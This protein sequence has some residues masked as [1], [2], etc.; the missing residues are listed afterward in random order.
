MATKVDPITV[1]VIRNGFVAASDEMKINL[2]RT[3]YNPIIYEVLDFSVGMFDENG[4][5]I[6]Q[7]AGLPIFLGNLSPSVKQIITDIGKE[8]MS[9]GDIYLIND[10]YTVGTHLNDVVVCSP[11]FLE[12][13]KTLVGFAASRAHWLDIGAVSPGGWTTDTTE[14]Y[15]EGIRLRSIQLMKGGVM[16]RDVYQILRD[17]VRFSDSV[18]GDVRAQIAACHTGERRMQEIVNRYGLDTVRAAIQ[19]MFRME[20]AA[21]RAAIAAIPDGVYSAEAFMDDDGVGVKNPKVKVTVRIE[22]DEMTI[23]LTGS[24]E[25]CL[26]PINCG[27]AATL[28]GARIALKAVTSPLSPVN[29]GTFVPLKLVVPENCMFNAKHPAP[30]AVYGLVLIT[31]IDTIF[32][33]LAPA[34]P[35]KIPAAHYGDVS[36]IFIFGTDPRTKTPYLHVEAQG[37]GWGANK[38]RDGENVMIAIADGDT[39][40]VPVEIVEA[41]YPLRVERYEIRQDS[42]GPGRY[43]GGLGH[44]RDFR[45]LDHDAQFTTTQE[46]SECP[47]WGLF[48]GKAGA[49]NRVVINPGT[50]EEKIIQ[51]ATGHP[52]KAGDLL[53]NQTGGGGGYG[54]PLDRPAEEVRLDVVRGYVSIKAAEES[55]GVILDPITLAIDYE[56]TKLKRQQMRN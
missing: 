52:L 2:T 54:N 48:G 29:E 14:I 27:Y 11:I 8:N 12:D 3:A 34:I 19:E 15:Q 56:A 31:L 4:N 5:M 20:E 47:P 35:H 53:S 30:S 50:P 36:A 26:G 45:I 40:N 25:Q 13:G 6:S 22:G 32:K 21:T 18:M 41:K 46:R 7:S 10:T 17:N 37:G 49:T 43:R 33:A 38:F 28:S 24:A 9:P 42:G 39:R 51:K 16:N 23:D 1:E 55:Y 44:Y